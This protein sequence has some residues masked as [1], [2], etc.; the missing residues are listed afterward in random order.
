MIR[1][2]FLLLCS[3]AHAE[4]FLS[5]KERDISGKE[6]NFG[7]FSGKVVLVVNTASRCGFTAQY[8]GLEEIYRKYKEKGFVVL[9]FPSND[10]SNQEPGDNAEIL[11]FC[12]EKFNITFPIFSK[13]ALLESSVFKLLT[14]IEPYTGEVKWNFEK[15]LLDRSGKLRGRYGAFTTPTSL[16]ITSKIEELLSE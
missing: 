10:F 13:S 6:I 8:Q 16:K 5:L 1:V 12:S 4:D 14:S 9:A 15:F 2:I 11:K 7:Q 3:F